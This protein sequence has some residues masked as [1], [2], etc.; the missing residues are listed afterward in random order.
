M[1]RAL[2]PTGRVSVDQP[3]DPDRPDATRDDE[4]ERPADDD[5]IDAVLANVRRR[6][7]TVAKEGGRAASVA[8]AGAAG[9]ALLESRFGP[10]HRRGPRMPRMLSRRSGV[11]DLLSSA[12]DAP[13]ALIDTVR[14]RLP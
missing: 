3:A 6:A 1:A 2:P 12:E 5:G 11:Q 7:A 9:G 14:R 10:R 13:E 8:V 4:G